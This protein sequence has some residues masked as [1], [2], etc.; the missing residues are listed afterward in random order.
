MRRN[1]G[2]AKILVYSDGIR[3]YSGD[4]R[5]GN[6]A[7]PFQI[8]QK[9]GELYMTVLFP[10]N[11]SHLAVDQSRPNGCAFYNRTVI[12]CVYF[13]IM[14]IVSCLQYIKIEIYTL[15]K[16]KVSKCLHSVNY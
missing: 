7:I 13:N 9:Q 10:R 14:K 3:L 1:V 12:S 2:P 8:N 16:H 11:L 4:D 15:K 5:Y 6:W